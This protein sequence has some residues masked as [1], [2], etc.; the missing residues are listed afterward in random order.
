MEC[1]GDSEAPGMRHQ[2]LVKVPG[3]SLLFASFLSADWLSVFLHTVEMQ[4]SAEREPFLS[5]SKI[6]RGGFWLV[7]I[8]SGGYSWPNQ[9]RPWSGVLPY[10]YSG[11]YVNHSNMEEKGNRRAEAL[12]RHKQFLSIKVFPITQVNKTLVWLEATLLVIAFF[13]TSD[14]LI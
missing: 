9:Q 5:Q 8:G 11:S 3:S 6:T 12:G 2:E 4:P 14:N 7:H 13:F 1:S 10:H